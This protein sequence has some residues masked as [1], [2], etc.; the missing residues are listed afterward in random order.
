MGF[1]NEVASDTS[2]DYGMIP[3]VLWKTSHRDYRTQI[4][5]MDL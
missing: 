2:H 3:A 4:K 5:C 1:H